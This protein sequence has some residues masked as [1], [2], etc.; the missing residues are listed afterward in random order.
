MRTS[1]ILKSY[2]NIIMSPHQ[3]SLQKHITMAVLG[4]VGFYGPCPLCPPGELHVAG[5]LVKVAAPHH[6][7]TWC[8]GRDSF[9]EAGTQCI[10]HQ[11]EVV[12]SNLG[13]RR[14]TFSCDVHL[15]GRQRHLSTLKTKCE[16]TEQ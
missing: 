15:G 8:F 14:A 11:E 13:M 6:L 16:Q 2:I 1:T 10:L 4:G 7:R 9:G 3:T 12:E 5:A